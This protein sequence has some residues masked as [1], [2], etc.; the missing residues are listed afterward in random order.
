MPSQSNCYPNGSRFLKGV[1]DS[2]VSLDEISRETMQDKALIYKLNKVITKRLL[3]FLED[4]AKNH[5]RLDELYAEFG[6]FLNK[7]P[8]W[9]SRTRSSS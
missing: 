4:E 6:I 3:K 7:V 2:E 8:P 5:A 9:I 1:V